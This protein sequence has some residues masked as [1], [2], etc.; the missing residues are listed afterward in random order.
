MTEHALTAE[1]FGVGVVRAVNAIETW[2]RPRVLA[3]STGTRCSWLLIG[4]GEFA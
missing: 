4:N 2:L 1:F 3:R